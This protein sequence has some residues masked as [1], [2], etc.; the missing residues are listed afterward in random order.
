M[1][2]SPF[3]RHMAGF[4]L[5][6][7]MIVVAIIGIISAIAYPS[8]QEYVLRGNRSEGQAFLNDA[9]ARQERYYA[10]NNTYADTAAKLGYANNNSSSSKYTLAISNVS[11]TTYTLTA[12]PAQTDSKCGNLTLNQAGTKGESGSGTLA[13]CWK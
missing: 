3:K 7:L 13:D 5:I 2:S 11:A 4:T 6:E 8:Y 1:H 9:A 10:Q 12:T